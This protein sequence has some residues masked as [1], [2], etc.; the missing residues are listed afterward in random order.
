MTPSFLLEDPGVI[1]PPFNPL[2]RDQTLTFHLSFPLALAVAIV[3]PTAF[4]YEEL[5]A[6]KIRFAAADCDPNEY[7]PVRE[8]G[9]ACYRT[10]LFNA[11]SVCSSILIIFLSCAADPDS[12]EVNPRHV[13]PFSSL[14][15]SLNS[16]SL[17]SHSILT[18]YLSLTLTTP[19][20]HQE[21][22]DMGEIL[23]DCGNDLVFP[24]FLFLLRM[25][26]ANDAIEVARVQVDV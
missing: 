24:R 21:V 25:L 9:I 17:N 14:Y 8:Y 18:H 1:A 15:H 19:T 13:F 22:V 26:V 16:H 2:A 10:I 7:D 20:V 3:F 23:S 6:A 4:E 5:K 11:A 12:P